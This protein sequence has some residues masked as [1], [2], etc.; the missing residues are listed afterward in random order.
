MKTYAIILAGGSGI[1]F[2]SEIPKQFVKIAGKL[3]IEHTIEVFEKHPLIDGIIIVTNPE[4]YT[5]LEEIV[6]NNA[7]HKIKKILNGG[8]YRQE[9]SK[10]GV[11]ACD[12]DVNKVL[13]HDAVRPFVSE[14]IISNIISLLDTYPS[15]DVAIPASDTIIKINKEKFIEEIPDRKYLYRG[16]TPQGFALKLIK[17]AHELALNDKFDQSPD[18]CSLILKYN[19]SKIFVIED[20]EFNIKITY[21]L[22]IH[23][24]DKIFQVHKINLANISPL[25]VLESVK[26]KV[27]VIFG[28]NSG[29][30]LEIFNLCK[31]MNVDVYQFSR[32]NGV[33]I[34]HYSEVSEA[35]ANVFEIHK[36]IDCIICSA[37]ILKLNVIETADIEEIKDQIN[38]NFL[39]NILVAKASIPFLKQTKGHLLFFASSSYT[40]GRSGYTP[41]SASKAALVN[42][43]QGLSEEV[44]HYSIK[45]NVVNP[46]RTDTPL[47]RNNF[48]KEDKSLL[49]SPQYVAYATMKALATDISGAVIEV[50]KKDEKEFNIQ[51]TFFE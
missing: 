1:R 39:G 30:G 2:G 7:Y 22:D 19:L 36:K 17:K 3:I 31:K 40:R 45:V 38:V 15:I 41:Y 21:P 24:A 12:D 14:G 26:N 16:Q 10:I 37:G 50:R 46:E 47:R 32:S 29:I 13:I 23:I 5:R 42:F 20:S 35:L 27:I 34:R 28:G 6:Q 25:D 44:S 43:V 18:D 9:S 11:F 8:E 51:G 4:Y 49:L 33:D 48:G